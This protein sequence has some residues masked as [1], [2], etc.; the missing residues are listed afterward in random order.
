M[1]EQ[2]VQRLKG[3]VVEEEPDPTLRLSVSAFIS[4]DYVADSHQRLSLLQAAVF[5]RAAR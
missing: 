5:L 1:V 3:Q 4:E 2:A